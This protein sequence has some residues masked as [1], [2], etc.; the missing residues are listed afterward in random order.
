MSGGASMQAPTDRARRERTASSG[1]QA[2]PFVPRAAVSGAAATM[3]SLRFP[4]KGYR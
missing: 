1:V 2:L 3:M 4:D